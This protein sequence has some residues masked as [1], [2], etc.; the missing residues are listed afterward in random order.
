MTPRATT[1][2][3]MRR[4]PVVLVVMLAV[5]LAACSA[6]E[7]EGSADP[8]QHVGSSPAPTEPEGQEPTPDAEDAELEDTEL[9]D[10]EPESAEDP[11]TDD[12]GPTDGDADVAGEWTSH[13]EAPLELTE[14][15][16]APFGGAVWTAGGLTGDGEATTAVLIYDPTFDT[17][18]EGPSL[19]TPVHHAAMVNAGDRLHVV[20]GYTGSGFDDPTDA[21]HVLDP[22]SG[23]WVPGPPLHAPRAAGAAAWDG[24]RIVYGGG[25]GSEGLVGDI[26]ALTG[27]RWEPA[28][29]LSD[30][31][32]HLAAASDGQGRVWFLA[33]R[34]GG[35]DT[36]L[37][38]VDLV[39]ASGAGR[40][41]D[42]P[43]PR[44]GVAG[45]YLAGAGACA[46][47][48]EGT[49]GTFDEVECID[50]EGTTTVLPALQHARHGLGAAVVEDRAY[51]VLGGPEPGLFVS[52]V[53]EALEVGSAR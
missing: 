36:N 12:C 22:A 41:G 15:A 53:V 40:L 32:E 6:P 21:V 45:L 27:D 19:P 2:G 48:G 24:E 16:A 1:V 37:G 46:L 4:L 7:E 26:V 34:T 33:G 43:T 30:P 52:A 9:G 31:R 18:E 25:V 5:V 8:D 29:D 47:G 13:A 50:A 23:E 44:G 35:F 42:L 17:W 14:V 39:D 38:T 3:G 20:G 49:H 10:I 51:A 28:G 11:A